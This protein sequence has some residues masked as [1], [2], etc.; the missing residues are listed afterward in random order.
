MWIDDT[1]NEIQFSRKK[2]KCNL[3]FEECIRRDFRR[4]SC[5]LKKYCGSCIETAF[6]KNKINCFF[7]KSEKAHKEISS[8]PQLY[9][10][11]YHNTLYYD[12]NIYNFKFL[13][14]QMG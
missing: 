4:C 10:C 13:L 9:N 1:L 3:C 7:C 11:F 8:K 12:K 6:T 2:N 5:C 14:L